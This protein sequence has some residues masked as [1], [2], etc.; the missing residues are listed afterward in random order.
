MSLSIRGR[1]PEDGLDESRRPSVGTHQEVRTRT[2]PDGRRVTRLDPSP[3]TPTTRLSSEG[4]GA[5]RT[6]D[7]H[8]NLDT[9]PSPGVGPGIHT[10]T[11]YPGDVHTGSGPRRRRY[12]VTSVGEKGCAPAGDYGDPTRP[13]RVGCGT[14]GRT[15]TRPVTFS[16]PTCPHP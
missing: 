1:S 6:S 4:G 12:E 7:T 11:G 10:R 2:R 9:G 8:S 15:R 16:C 3:S 14:G 13:R 5:R